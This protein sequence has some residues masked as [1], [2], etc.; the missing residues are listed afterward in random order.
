M[1]FKSHGRV[2]GKKLLG[3]IAQILSNEAYVTL[4]DTCAADEQHTIAP[5]L[6]DSDLVT[7]ESLTSPREVNVSEGKKILLV[8][9]NITRFEEKRR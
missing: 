9:K 6:L 7:W 3:L 2:I 5:G 4:F 8:S 1:R